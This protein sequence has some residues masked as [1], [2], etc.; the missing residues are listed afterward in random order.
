MLLIDCPHKWDRN[1]VDLFGVV[2][3]VVSI[4]F[5]ILVSV[6]AQATTVAVTEDVRRAT[7]G[8]LERSSPSRS[9]YSRA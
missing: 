7:D 3:V 2:L 9:T 4:V 8:I 6:Y 1:P 5:V